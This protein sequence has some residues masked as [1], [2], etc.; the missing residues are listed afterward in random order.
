VK[1]K[2][3]LKHVVEQFIM[4]CRNIHCSVDRTFTYIRAT[5][6][7]WWH[8]CDITARLRCNA[9]LCLWKARL[10]DGGIWYD[11]ILCI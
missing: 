1:L 4:C 3:K 11:M 5:L 6:L 9:F 2:L 7:N 8:S 10:G